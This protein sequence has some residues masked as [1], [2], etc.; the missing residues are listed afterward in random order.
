M[1]HPHTELKLVNPKV[2]LGVFATEFIP[3]GTIV[4][5]LDK[6]ELI[7]S[8]SDPLIDDEAYGNIIKHFS[9]IDEK[10]NRIIS[11]DI[12][13][14]V[15]HC[16]NFNTISTGYGFEIAIRDIHPGEEITDEYGLFNIEEE[17][18][19]TCGYANCRKQILF[20]DIDKYY[21]EWDELIKVHLNGITQLKQPLLPFVDKQIKKELDNY[22]KTGE[23]Y[24]SV[25]NLKFIK[26]AVTT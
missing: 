11:W 15:N 14:Y 10:G 13:K 17:M 20:N 2:G 26:E 25:Y 7:V 22:L 19:L 5:V 4:Y 12:A 21:K 8:P 23:N 1:I 18:E 3:A 6:L 24:N 9:Y 16:C